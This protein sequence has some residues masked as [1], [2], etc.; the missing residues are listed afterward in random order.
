MWKFRN[1]PQTSPIPIKKEVLECNNEELEPNKLALLGEKYK[2]R[3]L[4]QV[5]SFQSFLFYGGFSCL[6]SHLYEEHFFLVFCLVIVSCFLL[7]FSMTA[8]ECIH[9]L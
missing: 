9:L 4:L 6:L 5:V 3:G 8:M 1:L 2:S 7:K